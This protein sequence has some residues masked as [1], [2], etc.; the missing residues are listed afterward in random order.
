MVL[1]TELR[2]AYEYW[3]SEQGE[4]PASGRV[5]NTMLE[6]RGFTRKQALNPKTRINKTHWFG[7]QIKLP[8]EDVVSEKAEA[9]NGLAEALQ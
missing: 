2:K 4:Q 5:F 6:E 9:F 8:Y 3:C 1:V 7:L